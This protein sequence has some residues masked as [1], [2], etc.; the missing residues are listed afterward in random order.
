M[1]DFF[2]PF[3]ASCILEFVDVEL[4]LKSEGGTD[5]RDEQDDEDDDNGPVGPETDPC[6][7]VLVVGSSL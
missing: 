6:V 5:P 2:L 4:W 3:L 1:N 7:V